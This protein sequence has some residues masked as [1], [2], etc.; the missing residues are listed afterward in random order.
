LDDKG[1]EEKEKKKE[2]HGQENHKSD[3]K[4]AQKIV[5][6]QYISMKWTKK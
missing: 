2:K 5:K 6:H 3:V 1:S 4:D